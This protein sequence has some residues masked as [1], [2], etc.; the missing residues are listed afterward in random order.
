MS[1][2]C[3]EI[4]ADGGTRSGTNFM[5]SGEPHPDPVSFFGVGHPQPSVGEYLYLFPLLPW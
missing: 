3:H 2:A 5:L 1:Q 4:A